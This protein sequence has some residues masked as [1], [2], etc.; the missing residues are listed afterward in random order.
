MRRS[1][2]Q[3][4][5]LEA[6][7]HNLF[8]VD[9]ITITPGSRFSVHTG[10]RPLSGRDLF[11]CCS[12][13]GLAILRRDTQANNRGKRSGTWLATRDQTDASGNGCADRARGG[14]PEN[15]WRY[16]HRPAAASDSG[17]SHRAGANRGPARRQSRSDGAPD[18]YA[19]E[20][21]PGNPCLQPRNP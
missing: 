15:A 14:R 2:V 18:R 7:S 12:H 8:W 13:S 6:S 3:S 11:R 10:F 1:P 5:R 4:N 17:R 19:T 21:Q 16:L 9:F 20:L